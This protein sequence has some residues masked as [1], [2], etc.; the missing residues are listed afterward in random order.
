MSVFLEEKDRKVCLLVPIILKTREKS[1][2]GVKKREKLRQLINSCLKVSKHSVSAASVYRINEQK[3]L[4]SSRCLLTLL[5]NRLKGN[6]KSL[7]FDLS[8]SFCLEIRPN[9]KHVGR[10]TI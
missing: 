10:G 5:L 1:V 4:H 9:I 3:G 2:G 8:H 6:F 7:Q